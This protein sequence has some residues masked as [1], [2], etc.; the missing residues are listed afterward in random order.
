MEFEQ[1]MTLISAGITPSVMCGLL[2]WY[3]VQ[4][5]AAH[6]E[7]TNAMRDAINKLEVA[8]TKLTDKIED[9]RD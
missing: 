9:K 3:M 5:N 1:I 6:K 8:I 2:F 7:E 4:Q